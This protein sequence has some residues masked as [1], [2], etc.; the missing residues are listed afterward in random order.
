L[1]IDNHPPFLPTRSTKSKTIPPPQIDGF[2]QSPNMEKPANRQPETSCDEVLASAPARY[3]TPPIHNEFLTLREQ[4]QNE[5]NF[6]TKQKNS[7]SEL[8]TENIGEEIQNKLLDFTPGKIEVSQQEA[9]KV[10]AAESVMSAEDENFKAEIA[11]VTYVKKL[12]ISKTSEVMTSSDEAMTSPEDAEDE[13]PKQELKYDSNNV[14]SDCQNDFETDK[15]PSG[16]D[17][18]PL[19]EFNFSLGSF[20][21]YLKWQSECCKTNVNKPLS[22]LGLD[23][24][25]EKNAQ[26]ASKCLERET[27]KR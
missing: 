8:K 19:Y 14:F 7:A 1:T 10:H 17:H 5:N 24:S 4:E 15:N 13:T 26:M 23:I 25:K 22:E 16:I 2:K 12:I 20:N 9:T 11:L 18:Q 21:A 27:D 3:K 6:E